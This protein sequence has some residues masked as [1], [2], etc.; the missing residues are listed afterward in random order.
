MDELLKARSGETLTLTLNRPDK[1]NALSAAL[2]DALLDAVGEAAGDGTRLL[3]LKGAGRNFSAGFDFGGYEDQSEGDLLLRFVRIE[4]LLQ[5]LAHAPF[6]TL[7][8]AHGRNFGAGV[9]VVCACGR[10]VG[11]PA[12]TFRMPGLSFGLV[13]GTRRYADRVGG[14]KARLVLQEG[15]VFD[16]PEALSDGFLTAIAAT[17]SWSDTV[18]AA[19]EAATRLSPWAGAALNRAAARDT[20]ADDL[21]DLVASAARP[22]LKDRIRAYRA[23]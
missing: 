6:D 4:M 23:A 1:M 10:R 16:A 17:E 19:S 7:A 11:D 12:A 8:L 21:A 20:R 13:L 2:V 3:V 9:D 14:S 5:A 22:G 18:A 15:R